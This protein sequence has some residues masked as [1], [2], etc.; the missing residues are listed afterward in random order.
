MDL[1]NTI[2]CV[3]AVCILGEQDDELWGRDV[4]IISMIS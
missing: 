2:N 3:E 4:R 1:G